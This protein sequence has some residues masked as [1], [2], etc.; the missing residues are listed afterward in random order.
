MNVGWMYAVN[1]SGTDGT[2]LAP[3]SASAI[4]KRRAGGMQ[5]SNWKWLF[6]EVFV[7]I[8]IVRH[9]LLRIVDYKGEVLKSYV[10]RKRDKEAELQFIKK[11]VRWYGFT[12]EIVTNKL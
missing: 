9:S 2:G 3:S 7:K 8:N 1:L 4:K 12:N 5:L 10:I 11:T 6:D